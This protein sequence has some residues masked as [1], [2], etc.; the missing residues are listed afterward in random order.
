M[1]LRRKSCQLILN[2]VSAWAWIRIYLRRLSL[3]VNGN[4]LCVS[5]KVIESL[6]CST[7][8]LALILS[9]G[10]KLTFRRMRV[11]NLDGAISDLDAAI[12]SRF[13]QC[14]QILLGHLD[15]SNFFLDCPVVWI[16]VKRWTTELVENVSALSSIRFSIL[17]III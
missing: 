4:L 1:L 2:V 9:N 5:S 3:S 15:C 16:V 13:T 8:I 11:H 14:T 10:C 6:E 7:F 17:A 12:T